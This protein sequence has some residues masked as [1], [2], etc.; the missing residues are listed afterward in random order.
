M[1]PTSIK[2]LPQVRWLDNKI[3]FRWKIGLRQAC[4]TGTNHL[5]AGIISRLGLTNNT[6]EMTVL[7][8]SDTQA[9]QKTA[10]QNRCNLMRLDMMMALPK[11]RMHQ[12]LPWMQEQG[13][14]FSHE[15]LPADLLWKFL[16]W[17]AEYYKPSQP[18]AQT[19]LDQ[20]GS[21]PNYFGVVSRETSDKLEHCFSG[22]PDPEGWRLPLPAVNGKIMVIKGT[23]RTPARKLLVVLEQGWQ[24][25]E[26]G[27][28]S[29]KTPGLPVA[30]YACGQD[31]TQLCR[32][33]NNY[34]P[35]R[36]PFKSRQ[37]EADTTGSIGVPYGVK[38]RDIDLKGDL[39]LGH[40]TNQLAWLNPK[41]N[42]VKSGTN[43]KGSV[44][45][46]HLADYSYLDSVQG[47]AQYKGIPASN[48]SFKMLDAIGCDSVQIAQQKQAMWSRVPEGDY[49]VIL[50]PDQRMD[51]LEAATCQ[52]MNSGLLRPD[53][54]FQTSRLNIK[55]RPLVL[56]TPLN[57]FQ[58]STI[59]NK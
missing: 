49:A 26:L 34:F 31:S 44:S 37:L 52:S 24:I 30:L 2:G 54:P 46:A 15:Q 43:L 21:F 28:T 19:I 6:K 51:A 39:T 22:C 11:E 9:L 27:R 14:L 8:S 35:G 45:W 20:L 59:K 53:L 4:Q 36:R 5:A 23:R 16:I 17:A 3:Q 1:K 42:N 29:P 33:I 12:D 38:P 7:D 41:L 10:D 50:E 55:L 58:S 13:Y 57:P 40:I 32:E 18:A 47:R 48:D 25:W 56:Y